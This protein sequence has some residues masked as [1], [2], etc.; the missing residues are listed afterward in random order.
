MFSETTYNVLSNV[1]GIGWYI[2]K[3]LMYAGFEKIWEEKDNPFFWFLIGSRL[4]I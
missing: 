1:F 3:E 2:T 4:L